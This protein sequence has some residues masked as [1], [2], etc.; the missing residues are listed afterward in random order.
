ME[1]GSNE[2]ICISSDDDE[3]IEQTRDKK[4]IS[5]IEKLKNNDVHT[6]ER[7]VTQNKNDCKGVQGQKR[8]FSEMNNSNDL[9]GENSADMCEN[10]RSAKICK[11]NVEESKETEKKTE[12]KKKCIKPTLIVKEKKSISLLGQDV[13]PMFISLCLQKDHSDDMRSIVNKLKRRHEQLQPEYAVSEAFCNFLNE[14]RNEIINSKNKL[15]V[16]LF[17][18]MNEMKNNSNRKS[19][20]VS[21]SNGCSDV[22]N[23]NRTNI[24]DTP[25]PST[26]HTSDSICTNDSDEKDD[27]DQDIKK[28]KIIRKIEKAM[29]KCKNYIKRYENEEVDFNDENNSTYMKQARYKARMV[30]L[31]NKYCEYTGENADAGR[32]FLRP[33]HFSPTGIVVVDHAI[34]SFINSKILKRK[35]AKNISAFTETLIFPDYHDILQLVKKCNETNNLGLDNRKQQQLAR[36]AFTQIG[37]HLQ[38]CRRNDYWDTFSMFLENQE[39]DPAMKDYAL[40]EQLR[41]SKLEGNKK[42]ADVLQEYVEK[43]EK[44]K[45]EIVDSKVSPEKENDGES[46]DDEYD[47]DSIEDEGASDIDADLNIEQWDHISTD[48]EENSVDEIKIESETNFRRE[49]IDTNDIKTKETKQKTS[50]TVEDNNN[51]PQSEKINDSKKVNNCESSRDSKSTVEKKEASSNLKTQVSTSLTEL[52]PITTNNDIPIDETKEKSVAVDDASDKIRE[53][54]DMLK[55]AVQE[56]EKEDKPLLR[57]RSFAKPPTTWEDSH[58]KMDK[59]S[60][61]QSRTPIDIVD[62]TQ[63]SPKEELA[64]VPHGKVPIVSNVFPAKKE[65]KMLMVPVGNNSKIGKTY[66]ARVIKWNRNSLERGEIAPQQQIGGKPSAK[67]TIIQL[68]V[69]QRK[70]Q[71]NT[72]IRPQSNQ[73]ITS[74]TTGNGI[75]P[76]RI[77]KTYSEKSRSK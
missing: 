12:E 75:H 37:D 46:D 35:K 41:Q 19:T 32:H 6:R 69:N 34:T 73:I 60:E 11:L 38:L 16:Y 18:V 23:I 76:Q 48:K 3:N 27:A 66:V 15:Y 45:D 7:E 53:P 74:P 59:Q 42:I 50:D 28:R 20:S 13:F 1:S 71:I 70:K 26:S 67:A 55:K 33:K 39:D 63:T 4:Q 43:Q 31:Y 10:G 2:V 68:P 51:C 56:N 29:E 22:N 52:L 47:E 65:F 9:N 54:E 14:K 64:K 17:E 36:K 5:V 24:L 61:N 21:N 58:G 30:E 8:K 77:Q 62:L 72:N 25:V 49:E 40:A 44:L 57:V